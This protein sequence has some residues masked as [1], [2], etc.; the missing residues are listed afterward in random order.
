MYLFR[1]VFG[2][3]KDRRIP[4]LRDIFKT[5][6]REKVVGIIYFD[7]V[8]P[9]FELMER[10]KIRTF[11]TTLLSGCTRNDERCTAKRTGDGI[12]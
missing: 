4:E 6:G 9:I 5:T 1:L 12:L 10:G 3:S 8:N 2:Q 11:P 7:F